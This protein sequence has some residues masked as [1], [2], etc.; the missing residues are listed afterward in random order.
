MKFKLFSSFH[1]LLVIK[2]FNYHLQA[3]NKFSRIMF[4]LADF[5]SDTKLRNWFSKELWQTVSKVYPLFFK[6]GQNPY[7]FCIFFQCK[8]KYSTKQTINGKKSVYGFMVCLRFKPRAM[9][10]TELSTERWWN[11]FTTIFRLNL[12][13]KKSIF[14]GQ[15]VSYPNKGKQNRHQPKSHQKFGLL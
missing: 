5:N 6:Y 13:F 8:Y 11:P 2:I 3:V 15:A 4:A 14:L 10:D 12:C 1:N 7:S 9:V